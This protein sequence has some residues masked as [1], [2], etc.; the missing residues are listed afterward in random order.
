MKKVVRGRKLFHSDLF[1]KWDQDVLEYF[2]SS[3]KHHESLQ[4]LGSVS[5]DNIQKAT[6]EDVVRAYDSGY[7]ILLELHRKLTECKVTS[8][9]E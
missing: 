2:S 5:L 6:H 4:W 3:N 1:Q 7:K 9:I 8:V